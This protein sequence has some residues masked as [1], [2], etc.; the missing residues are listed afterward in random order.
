[1]PFLALL[2]LWGVAELVALIAVVSK[3]GFF[4]TL[5]L[6]L[7]SSAIGSWLLRSQQQAVLRM[8]ETPGRDV[9]R[10]SVYRMTA[11]VLLLIPGFISS[12]LALVFLVPPLRALFAGLLLR[13]LP[14]QTV[15]STF[16]WQQQGNVYEHEAPPDN[17]VTATREDGT[18]IHGELM[19]TRNPNRSNDE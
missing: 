7:L 18:V 11:G 1:M 13:V 2:G 15:Y 4:A 12:A 6:L 19:D 5:G 8:A 3:I 16:S 14:T 9:A 10:E 17:D